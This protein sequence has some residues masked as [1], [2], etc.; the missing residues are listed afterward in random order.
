MRSN[1]VNRAVQF[2]FVIF[3]IMFASEMF[4]RCFEPQPMLPRYIQ[5]GDFGVRVNMPSLS[6]DHNT[7]DYEVKIQTNAKGIRA[8]Q[9]FHYEKPNHT[10]RIVV[11]SDSFGM[12]YGVNFN[13]TFTEI[14]RKDLE[15]RAGK[16]IEIINLS[17][18]G[19]GTAEQLLMLQHE[20]IKFHPDLVLLTWH[21]TD[22]DDNIRSGLYRI[23]DNQL[24]RKNK[25]Y[26]PGVKI[27]ELLFDY[28]IYRW[29][30][31]NSHFYNWVRQEAATLVKKLA[32]SAKKQIKGAEKQT[33]EPESNNKQLSIVKE[34]DDNQLSLLL[35]KQIEVE[36]EQAGAQLLILEIP[37]R[38]SRI[39]FIESVPD[40]FRNQFN[41]VNPIQAFQDYEGELLFWERSHGHFT[42][43]GCKIIGKLLADQIVKN[44][45][46]FIN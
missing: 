24:I 4:L 44:D 37:R 11:L 12:G 42:P 14:M 26:L 29:L 3:W 7:P 34:V 1:F 8:N 38:A 16:K 23:E 33:K 35:L 25:E 31:G 39:K 19:Y 46:A 9:E 45:Y 15:L 13:D 17:V 32:V 5:A 6:Y 22:P 2:I 40:D 18:S 10:K 28:K 30:A 21:N 41:I 20:G 27:R 43:L 36:A